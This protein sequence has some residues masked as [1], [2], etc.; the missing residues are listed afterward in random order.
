[1]DGKRAEEERPPCPHCGGRLAPIRYG[2][3]DFSEELERALDAGEIVLGGCELASERWGCPQCG[4]RY[5]DV[6]GEHRSA[7]S[8]ADR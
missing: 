1:M 7:G 2:L 5:V 6:P 4:G 3:P 8:P